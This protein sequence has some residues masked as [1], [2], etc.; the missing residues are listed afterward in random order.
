MKLA[1][2][3]FL[4]GIYG[5]ILNRKHYLLV[6][7]SIE[8]LLLAVTILVLY[9]SI[10]HDDMLA[11][12]FGLYIISMAAAETAV[13]LSILVAYHRLRGT[14]NITKTSTDTEALLPKFIL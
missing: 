12:I 8:I 1:L 9:F 13:A 2:L 4:I 7:I 6:L 14:I 11:Q 5:I 10:L 3:L